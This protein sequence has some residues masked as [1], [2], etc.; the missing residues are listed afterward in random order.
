MS[1]SAGA[2]ARP[3]EAQAFRPFAGAPAVVFARAAARSAL[4][5]GVR[6]GGDEVVVG[7]AAG[8]DAQDT[9]VRARGELIERM[10]NIVAGREAEAGP[11]VRATYRRLH[12]AGRPAVDPALLV[13]GARGADGDVRDAA[14]LWAV[15]RSLTDG[16]DVLVPA[17]AVYLRHRPP[18]GCRAGISAGS[19]GV[20]AH[21][22]E[23]TARDHALWEILERDLIRRSWYGDDTEPPVVVP[24]RADPGLC[25]SLGL[26]GLEATAFLLP[27]PAGAVCV[28][29]C[30]HA[31]DGTGQAFGA[32]CGPAGRYPALA[33]KAAYEALMVRWSMDTPVA[34]ET[35]AR[36]AGA[37][38]PATALEHA[39]WAYHRQ[40]SLALWLAEARHDHAGPQAPVGYH[41]GPG[42]LLAAHTGADVIAVP[43]PSPQGTEAGLRV[44]RA[45]APGALP[46]P[47]GPAGAA[48]PGRSGRP[49]PFG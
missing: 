10:G 22:D 13:H 35:W 34:R 6:A 5:T 40:D 31:P 27:A 9:A 36:W 38:E 29:V 16:G 1:G 18:P 42:P 39:L 24:W 44:V 14:L 37:T 15:G 26:L 41:A 25:E 32:R 4:F 33:G 3:W 49:H 2:P 30:V 46:L 12:R 23:A 47:G 17:G 21:P 43:T 45:V 7:S 8:Q 19:T 28:V 11:G 20:A 48:G